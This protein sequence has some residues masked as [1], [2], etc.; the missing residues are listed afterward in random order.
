MTKSGVSLVVIV[1]YNRCHMLR[2]KITEALECI[3]G[4]Q[5]SMQ[6]PYIAQVDLVCISGYC[7]SDES[8]CKHGRH[9]FDWQKIGRTSRP[10]ISSILWVKK[11]SLEQCV[12]RVVSHYPVAI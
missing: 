2:H 8:L 10:T 4:V 3:L 5:Q 7:I 11:N 9:V 1:C 6:L 12:P